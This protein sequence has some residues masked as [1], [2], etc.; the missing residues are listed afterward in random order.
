MWI[1][2]DLA[3]PTVSEVEIND[4][5]QPRSSAAKPS[6]FFALLAIPV[7]T[8]L[9]VGGA[10]MI[11]LALLVWPVGSAPPAGGPMLAPSPRPPLGQDSGGGSG[12]GGS[13]SGGSSN[14]GSS[15]PTSA[16]VGTVTDL[17]TGQPGAGI[18]V[19]VNGQIVRTDTDG[20]Y[21]ITGLTAGGYTVSPELGGQGEA[22]QSAVYVNVDGQNSVTVDLDYYS[23]A[24]PLPTDTPQPA[25]SAA[26]PPPEL[27]N[28]GGVT[29]HRPLV[30]AGFGML[31][32]AAGGML[33]LLSRKQTVSRLPLIVSKKLF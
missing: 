18:E 9:M 30:I 33:H 10:L 20:S 29:A 4:P 16:I 28:S 32:V 15:G 19:S 11:I 21:S 31:L 23:Q 1:D 6:P 24:Q 8:T 25:V 2:P 3:P 5:P 22:A 26:D 17:S 12:D 7:K 27:P 13:D 14:S